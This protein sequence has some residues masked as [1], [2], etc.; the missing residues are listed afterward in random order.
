[1]ANA[2]EISIVTYQSQVKAYLTGIDLNCL[3]GWDG[4]ADFSLQPL[5]QGEYN[6]NFLLSQGWKRF[7]VR[8]N[9]GSQI[10]KSLP[11]QIRYEFQTLKMLE[12]AGVTP[13]VNY[14]DDGCVVLPYGVMIMEYLPGEKLD[15][16]ED[17]CAA[18]TLFAK[19]HQL[20][21]SAPAHLIIE[22]T[23]L[24]LTYQ[25]CLI[26]AP[27]YWESDLADPSVSSFL[28]E[29]FAWADQARL[30]EAF[31]IQ[32]P[33][34]CVINTEVNNG[35]FIKNLKKHTLH[36][37]DWEKPLWGDPSQDL[38]H[39]RVPTTTLWKTEYRMSLADQMD[40]MQVYKGQ[41][42]DKHLVDTIEERT[43]LRDPFNCLRG[44]SWCAMAWVQY[45][46]GK[47]I[48]R[49]P[50]TWR[51]LAKYVDLEFL[52]DLFDPYLKGGK[53]A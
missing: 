35:N 46:T 27:K 41:L 14:L 25:R 11:E 21:I 5:A 37:V 12:P 49:N 53:F 23:P 33:W 40:M 51:K 3:P 44:V 4:S 1:M 24:S 29:I 2:H 31:F 34:H 52:H 13:K 50:D 8:V 43:R 32:D 22:E 28:K 20:E 10:G 6:M 48:L 39:Y 45:Q 15:Y 47:H 36:L 38:S 7:V 19:Y 16:L 42:M 26:M 17:N 18:A 9:T 30:R